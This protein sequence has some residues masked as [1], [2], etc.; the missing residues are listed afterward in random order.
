MELR[1][2]GVEMSPQM[3]RPKSANPLNVDVKV[4]LDEATNQSLISYCK[5]HGITRAQAIRNGILNLL[6][7]DEK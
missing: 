2:R 6:K 7:D 1:K 3:G 4:R 5:K